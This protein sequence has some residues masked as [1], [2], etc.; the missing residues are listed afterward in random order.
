MRAALAWAAE[1]RKVV[2]QKLAADQVTMKPFELPQIPGL[3][4][5]RTERMGYRWPQE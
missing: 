3:P 4:L 5:T 1:T 2:R